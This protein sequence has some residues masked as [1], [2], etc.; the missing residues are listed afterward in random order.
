MPAP[1]V[2]ITPA[3][4]SRPAPPPMPTVWLCRCFTYQL[5]VT[6]SV[7]PWWNLYLS[8]R[9]YW[10]RASAEKEAAEL[11]TATNTVRVEIV[12]IHGD[13]P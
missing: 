9:P 6:S 11:R 8:E 5:P 4:D 3:A 12:T 13:G 1:Q 7:D 2:T 10:S